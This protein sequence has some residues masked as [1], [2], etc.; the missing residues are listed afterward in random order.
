MSST[1]LKP[2]KHRLAQNRS[3]YDNQIKHTWQPYFYKILQVKLNN[4]EYGL[5]EKQKPKT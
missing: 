5:W 2:L 4:L 3:E 1:L